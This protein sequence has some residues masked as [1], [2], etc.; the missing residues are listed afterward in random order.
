MSDFRFI[1]RYSIANVDFK[2]V[3]ASGVEVAADAPPVAEFRNYAT[4][5]QAWSRATTLLTAPGTYRVVI[6]SVETALPG[7][8][9]IMFPHTISGVAQTWRVDIEIPSTQSTTYDALSDGYRGIVD[10]VWESFTDMFDSAVG[11]P[12]LMM[13]S[14]SNFGRERVAQLMRSALGRMNTVSQPHQSYTIDGS[15]DFPFIE[16]GPLLEQATLVE[17]IKHLMRSYVEQPD[18]QGVTVARLDRRDYLQRWQSILDIEQKELDDGLSVFKMASM[19]LGRGSILVSGGAY[20]NL[21]P[22]SNP[23]RRPRNLPGFVR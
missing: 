20:G 15:A 21:T 4:G 23:A 19:N 18:A 10:N 16:W 14:Q 13:Y 11:G 6:S 17:V 3:N 9:Y 1:G 7:L 5:V 8:F 12:H 22:Y 2:V